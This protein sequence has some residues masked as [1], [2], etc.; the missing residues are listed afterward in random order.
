MNNQQQQPAASQLCS[1][2]P[3][4]KA[5]FTNLVH[6]EMVAEERLREALDGLT[7]PNGSRLAQYHL[8]R[9]RKDREV[10]VLEVNE[11]RFEGNVIGRSMS[12][13]DMIDGASKWSQIITG[14]KHAAGEKGRVIAWNID[15]DFLHKEI[16]I[17]GHRIVCVV[18]FIELEWIAGE[19]DQ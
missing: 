4:F 1:T 11:I 14:K 19:R 8:E 6:A 9:S 17:D 15:S 18:S 2:C 7:L 5:H 12:I 3:L 13:N 10:W 16:Q